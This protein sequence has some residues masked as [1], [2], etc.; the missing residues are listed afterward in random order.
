MC[1]QVIYV[2]IDPSSNYSYVSPKLVE[3]CQLAKE[4]HVEP[5][6]VKL[7]IGT[8]RRVSQWTKSCMF[9]LNSMPTTAHLNLF[10]LGAY[11]MLLGMDWLYNHHTKVDC[12]EKAIECL[13]EVG[14]RRIMKG[15]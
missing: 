7:T 12:Y 6:L 13:D 14:E 3:K 8:K 1:N 15:K 4:A 11:I 10:P 9:E 2:L 5:W